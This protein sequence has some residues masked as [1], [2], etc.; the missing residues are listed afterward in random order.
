MRYEKGR[1]T[2]L[3]LATEAARGDKLRRVSAAAGE[4]S[5]VLGGPPLRLLERGDD[6]SVDVVVTDLDMRDAGSRGVFERL[7]DGRLFPG[8]PQVH[9][10]RDRALRQRTARTHPFLGL[11]SLVAPPDPCELRVRVRLAAE[12]GRLRRQLERSSVLDP[13]TGLANRRFLLQRL[14]EEF[15]RARRHRTPLSL[16]VFEID[17]LEAL[18]ED[19]GRERVEAVVATVA[20]VVNRHVRREDVLG[21]IGVGTLA[22]VLPGNRYRGSAVFANQARTD[23]QEALESEGGRLAGVRLSAGISSYPD[24]AGVRCGGDLLR[25][26][27]HALDQARLR[28]GARVSIDESVLRHERPLVLVADQDRRL[29]ELTEDLLGLDDLRV[30]R[31]E[32][33]Q[34][35]LETLRFRRPD[36]LVLD[37]EMTTGEAGGRLVHTL[38][39]LAPRDRFPI[40]C[41]SREPAAT[42][43]A[44]LRVGVDRFV[45]KPFS[46]GVLRTIARELLAA[47][48]T[49]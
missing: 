19:I 16:V 6:E 17:D 33:A 18:V 31:A 13:G 3:V 10:F 48:R 49:A 24:H 28:G 32:S 15:S 7:L 21:R 25:T 38:Q 34:T 46:A 5:G 12:I 30:I 43:E 44:L 27:Q 4:P 8:L 40:I 41:M 36:L 45:T 47:R 9:L 35:A 42:P 23:L 37:L 14:D 2:V 26:T 29:L 11:V 22:V 1:G 20:T 39:S